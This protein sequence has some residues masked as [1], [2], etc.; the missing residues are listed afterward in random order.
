MMCPIKTNNLKN[1]EKKLKVTRPKMIVQIQSYYG[2]FTNQ[3]D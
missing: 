1:R 2:N 3:C